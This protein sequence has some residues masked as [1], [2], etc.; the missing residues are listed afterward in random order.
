M[1]NILANL[2]LVDK[3]IMFNEY[4]M[5]HLVETDIF[6]EKIE[7][8]VRF[9]SRTLD[10]LF[11][12]FLQLKNSGERKTQ[13]KLFYSSYVRFRMNLE[14]LYEYF[15]GKSSNSARYELF[16]KTLETVHLKIRFL[17]N[18]NFQT[19]EYRT[20]K[21]YINENE[22]AILLQAMEES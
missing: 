5:E 10:E 17:K 6:Q 15:S 3:M 18:Y 16:L 7:N 2:M 11:E 12:N 1:K 20:E 21:Q 14:Q 13:Y 9:I 22:Y 4:Y 8:D 19:N